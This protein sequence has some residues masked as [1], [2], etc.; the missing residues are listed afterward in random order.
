MCHCLT[1][2]VRNKLIPGFSCISKHISRGQVGDE[3]MRPLVIWRSK[4]Q[5]INHAY[6]GGCSYSA[7]T[8]AA[9]LIAEV[10]K[11]KQKRTRIRIVQNYTGIDNV[12]NRSTFLR[13]QGK[14]IYTAK[15]MKLNCLFSTTM[16]KRIEEPILLI[17]LFVVFG[18]YKHSV[19]F[20]SSSFTSEFCVVYKIIEIVLF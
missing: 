9:I 1:Q 17:R 15:T 6:Q 18:L 2:P 13:Y 3:K 16:N 12:E 20:L 19:L 5:R 7:V 8:G 10:T 14:I 4:R 11:M